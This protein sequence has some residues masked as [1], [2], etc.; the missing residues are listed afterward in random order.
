MWTTEGHGTAYDEESDASKQDYSPP[1]W[2]PVLHQK[3]GR[4]TVTSVGSRPTREQLMA[5]FLPSSIKDMEDLDVYEDWKAVGKEIYLSV[6]AALPP[7]LATP[8]GGRRWLDEW[9][10]PPRNKQ[11]TTRHRATLFDAILL[12]LRSLREIH[13]TCLVGHGEGA[14]VVMATLSAD[15]RDSAYKHRKVSAE[16][17][18]RLEEIAQGI[19]HALLLAPH[20][21]PTRTY[22]PF[23]RAYA[24]ELACILP[25]ETQVMAIIPERDATAILG[26]EAA[27]AVLGVVYE[28]VKFGGPAYRTIP[29]SP[30]I[31]YQWL[32][33]RR[34]KLPIVT[35]MEGHPP[36]LCVETWAGSAIL[37]N[38]LG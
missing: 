30:L 3:V 6:A 13:A 15:L 20:V 37:K 33:S 4:T 21:F 11:Q 14:I 5:L 2:K 22:M 9:V 28:T 7:Q 10:P 38:G 31:L 12:T 1:M 17:T 29:K 8:F 18:K 23:L 32:P 34:T 26:K 35:Q 16:E 25:G 27:Q 19:E 24:P 36:T